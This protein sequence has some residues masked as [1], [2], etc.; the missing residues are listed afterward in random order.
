ML[1]EKAQT[2]FFITLVE[3]Q[4]VA[5]LVSKTRLASFETVGT[6]NKW[7]ACCLV[8]EVL[9]AM[10]FVYLPFLNTILATVPLEM[11]VWFLFAPFAILLFL[12]EDWRKRF[13]RDSEN[14][15]GHLFYW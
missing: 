9:L 7:L 6:S 10:C 8:A 14:P 13:I 2:T 15:Q 3:M 12:I 1:L 5:A 4:I 11:L